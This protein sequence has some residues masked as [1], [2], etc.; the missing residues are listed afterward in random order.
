MIV[1]NGILGMSYRTILWLGLIRLLK[2]IYNCSSSTS[3]SIVGACMPGVTATSG[4]KSKPI[5]PKSS[6]SG[7]NF[8]V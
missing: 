3:R 5:H 8:G 7:S 2:D 6:I 4:S 1:G